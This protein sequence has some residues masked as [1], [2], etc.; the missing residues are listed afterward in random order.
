MNM[1]LFPGLEDCARSGA[2]ARWHW[3]RPCWSPAVVVVVAGMAVAAVASPRSR[4]SGK[5]T[6]QRVPFSTNVN[7]G[8]SYAST[9]EQPIREAIVELIQ[10]SGSTLATTT[11]DSNGNYALTAPAN[12][13]VFV[14]VQAQLRKT[15]TPARSIRVLNNTNGNALYVLD[16]AV[17]NSRGDEPDEE[18]ACRFRVGRHEY[19]GTPARPRSRSS[20]RCWRRRNS[21]SRTATRRSTCRDSMCS[22]ARRTIR[23]RARPRVRWA[24]SNP[25]CIPPHRPADPAA[26]IYVLGA[27]NVDTDE[28]DQHVL[29]HEFQHFL[30]DTISRSDSPG[31]PHAPGDRL[32]PRVAFSEGF[33][34]HSR[35]RS[36]TTR[37]TAT[38]SVF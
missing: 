9:S 7:L 22:G 34:T 25:P 27:E 24:R 28:Y 29:A 11:S 31:G 12:T 20:T 10:S 2:A 5:A 33:A 35:R 15:T 32:D 30:E 26:G 13:S 23:R 4:I 1:R 38:R 3:R 21:S 8:L 17:F 37:S 19:T 14:R 36:S 18:L 6:Y 16:G